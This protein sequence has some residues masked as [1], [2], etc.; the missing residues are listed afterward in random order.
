LP[1]PSYVQG[2]ITKA[3]LSRTGSASGIDNALPKSEDGVP[4]Q[5]RDQN[6][7]EQPENVRPIHFTVYE[8]SDDIVHTPEAAFKQGL[9]MVKVIK[10]S[11]KKLEL[12]SKL[13]RDVWDREIAT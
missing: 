1:I 2:D 10:E 11:L 13:R 9:G 3:S 4:P 12:G 7:Q 6:H 8:S 5:Q